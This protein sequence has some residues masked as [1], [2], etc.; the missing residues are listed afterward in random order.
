M[1]QTT[2]AY[3]GESG[4][5]AETGLGLL[6]VLLLLILAV[7]IAGLAVSNAEL[8]FDEAQYWAW[9][10]E[11]AF[12]YFTKPPLIAWLIGA[13]S[14]VCGDTPFCVRLPAPLLHFASAFILYAVAGKLFDQR[15]AF[16]S[17]LVYFLMPGMSLSSTLMSTDV[18]LL[19]FWIIGLWAIVHHVQKP[20]L[21]AGLALGVAVGLGLNAKYA[22]VYLPLCFVL[23]A[24]FTAEAR[25]ALKHPGTLLA[26]VVALVLIAPNVLWNMQHGFATF[27]H[28]RANAAW[29]GRFPNIKGVFEFIGNQAAIIGP[30][31]FVAFC[32][33]LAGKAKDVPAAPAR[34]LIFH[35]LPVFLLLIAQALIS[36]AN[37][38]WAVTGFPAAVILSVAVMV[39]LDWRRSMIATM[40]ISV[41]ALAVLSFAGA[42]A[43]VF[44]TGPAGRELGK[45]AGWGE[46]AGNVRRIADAGGVRTVVFPQR[47]LTA[48]MIYEL[49]DSGLDVRAYLDT[50]THP[51]DHF[52]LTRPW[53]AAD[54]G[55]VMFF[56]IGDTAPPSELLA[57]ATKVEVFPTQV[58]IAKRAGWVASAWR[59]D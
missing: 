54:A 36:K 4:I 23:Y 50:P 34:L 46:L 24:A 30:I 13:S 47:G 8:F 1:T 33:W 32:V 44:T 12:G 42:A 11:P 45:L 59:I 57:R 14:A 19:F 6:T 17:A 15:I 39:T 58:F 20:S 27:E 41:F 48:S 56:T 29:G 52:E 38:N 49:R 7:R 25:P 3:R 26:L 22:M 51:Q 35:S 10:Q 40:A 2:E 37:G 5:R 53:A 21:A 9:S 16:W 31:P 55:P 28:T 43:G 18:P